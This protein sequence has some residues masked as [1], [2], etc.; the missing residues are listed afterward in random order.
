M[1]LRQSNPIQMFIKLDSAMIPWN[2]DSQTLSRCL[3]SWAVQW[4]HGTLTVKPYSDVYQAGQCNDPMELWQ[5]NP[6][7]M[8]IKLGSAMIPWNSDSQTLCRCLSSWAMQWSHGTLVSWYH[9]TSQLDKH[10]HR[11]WLSEFHGINALPSLINIWIGFDCQSSMGSCGQSH[12]KI[13]KKTRKYLLTASNFEIVCKRK[14][15]YFR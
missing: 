8:F 14:D 15:N 1:E 12:N 11:V 3:S 9:C 6:I 10:L 13:W 2:S 4:S 7:Q 5:S